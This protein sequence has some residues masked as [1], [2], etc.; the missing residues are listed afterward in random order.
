MEER[1]VNWK[2]ILGEE[3]PEVVDTVRNIMVN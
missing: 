3:G 1:V 2:F